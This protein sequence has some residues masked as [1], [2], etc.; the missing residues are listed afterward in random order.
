MGS[1]LVHCCN[2]RETEIDRYWSVYGGIDLTV[3]MLPSKKEA[4][5]SLVPPKPSLLPFSD[6]P[7]QRLNNNE[8][9]L[10]A[11]LSHHVLCIVDQKRNHRQH[12]LLFATPTS[13]YK[14]VVN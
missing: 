3:P 7:Q 12:N 13:K 8:H 5:F 2:Q 4:P 14:Q 9:N 11:H 10:N 1:N 6:H